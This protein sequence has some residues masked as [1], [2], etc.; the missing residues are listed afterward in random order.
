MQ[1]IIFGAGM[2]GRNAM[3][4]LDYWRVACFAANSPGEPIDNK[5]VVSYASMLEM[6]ANG[7]YIIV[8][9]SARYNAEMVA[10]LEADGVKRYFVYH[11][12]APNEIRQ[13][14]PSYRL[15]RQTITV[16]YV[17]VLSMLGIS[18]YKRIA[19]YGDNFFLPY[20]IAEIAFHNNLKNIVGVIPTSGAKNVRSLGLPLVELGDV[21]DDIDCLVINER[22]NK[23][24]DLNVLEKRER[25]FDFADI[26]NIDP[27][28]S[29]FQH[30]ELAR[31]KGI[32]KGKRC[33]LIGNG[34]SMRIE[35]LD[36]L[37]KHGEIC[38]GFNKIY[39]I[40]DKT[41]WRPDYFGMED[42]LMMEQCK[43]ELASLSGERF[44]VDTYN[45][46]A[47]VVLPFGKY[48]HMICEEYD[49]NCPHFAEDI[50]K[51]VY[52][53]YTGVYSIGMQFAAYMG[54][55]EIY[56]LGVDCSWSGHHTNKGNHFIKDYYREEEKGEWKRRA[57]IEGNP[58]GEAR[59][60]KAFEAAERYSRQHG[61]RIYNATRG[62]KVEAFER[63]DFDSLFD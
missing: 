35:D 31:Y 10:Q 2:T 47:N 32:H 55:S 29:E 49:T 38:F 56:I 27:Y 41:N 17:K 54:V 15:Y 48:V 6:V 58:V 46:L 60:P 40:Y 45:T 61:F 33:F 14:Y 3:A 62:G 13:I 22:R 36:T 34:P 18:K 59:I 43:D 5:E 9:A 26:Y 42:P 4:F 28:I 44:F 12:S 20:L 53:G 37:H 25:D 24:K 16:P 21:W 30:P 57:N 50:T 51:G 63:V 7:D 1:Y 8:V 39:R 23:I 19:I 52:W 11:E